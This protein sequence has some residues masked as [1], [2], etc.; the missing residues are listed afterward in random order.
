[1]NI[2]SNK[3]NKN[4]IQRESFEKQ[5]YK[6]STPLTK[7]IELSTYLTSK[8]TKLNNNLKVEYQNDN[9]RIV[10]YRIEIV[11]DCHFSHP[12]LVIIS[13]DEEPIQYDIYTH[14]TRTIDN[15]GKKIATETNIGKILDKIINNENIIPHEKV[16]EIPSWRVIFYGLK[17]VLKDTNYDIRVTAKGTF[18]FCLKEDDSEFGK[19]Y[20]DSAN[21]TKLI[22]YIDTTNNEKLMEKIVYADFCEIGTISDTPEVLINNCVQFLKDCYF[23]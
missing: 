6:K 5:E 3:Y 18:T 1:M 23:I 19:I 7:L 21:N 2:I 10:I 13:Y 14:S 15:V 20:V 17:D 16:R 12:I 11:Y 22:M 4:A 9:N 8:I